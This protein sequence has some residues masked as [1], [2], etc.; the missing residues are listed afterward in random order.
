M[1]VSRLLREYNDQTGTI[2]SKQIED[3]VNKLCERIVNED[4]DYVLSFLNENNALA[5][6]A[7]WTEEKVNILLTELNVPQTILK[8]KFIFKLIIQ[9]HYEVYFCHILNS[10]IIKEYKGS[11]VFTIQSN[12]L[13][14]IFNNNLKRIVY[15]YMDDNDI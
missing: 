6:H 8:Y 5:K 1:S 11:K 4:K 7:R 10:I 13:D 3:H 9:D 2:N 14:K 15:K 12:D